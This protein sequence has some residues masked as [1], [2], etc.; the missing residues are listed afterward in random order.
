M[1]NE[2]GI[3]TSR[4][5]AFSDGVIAIILTIMVFDLKVP[6][7]ESLGW[8]EIL[9]VLPRMAWYALSF[10]TVGILWVSH[11][12][13]FHQVRRMERSLLWLNLHLLFWMS[14]IPFCTHLLARNTQPG[15]GPTVYGL[16]LF[17][18]SFSF[19]LIR[20]FVNRK[21]LL[22]SSISPAG[23]YRI[24]RKNR[25][26]MSLYLIGTGFGIWLPMVS[27]LCFILVPALYFVP[28]KIHHNP[29]AS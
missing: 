17:G 7:A 27:F 16:V 24:R 9:H 10:V 21:A 14:L 19:A 2:S 6:E 1:E 26:S 13:L 20:E 28:E 12:Q 29:A 8:A 15:P 25:L 11:H 23:Q 4:A 18:S 3:G 5:E 22:K